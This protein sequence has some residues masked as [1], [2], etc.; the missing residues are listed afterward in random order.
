MGQNY[1]N[2]SCEAKARQDIALQICWL[3]GSSKSIFSNSPPS[4]A[5]VDSLHTVDLV[6]AS[7]SLRSIPAV[8]VQGFVACR[9][10]PSV[11]DPLKDLLRNRRTILHQDRRLSTQ[12]AWAADQPSP[13][14][15]HPPTAQASRRFW[16]GAAPQSRNLSKH[17][18][19]ASHEHPVL[20]MPAGSP[21]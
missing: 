7:T 21:L 11:D 17:S 19:F 4:T 8:V 9:A 12:Q 1:L 3:K 6:T 15:L 20:S 13:R 16:K 5:S 18:W 10:Y 2:G 14:Q